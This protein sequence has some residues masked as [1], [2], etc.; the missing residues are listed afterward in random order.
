MERESQKFRGLMNTD[1]MKYVSERVFFIKVDE[2]KNTVTVIF[3]DESCMLLLLSLL[4]IVMSFAS[5]W[6]SSNS[7]SHTCLPL[8]PVYEKQAGPHITAV[9]QERASLVET[10]WI[11]QGQC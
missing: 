2:Q 11:P 5:V 8:L 7:V 9:F 4:L 6:L 10:K 1:T 3:I